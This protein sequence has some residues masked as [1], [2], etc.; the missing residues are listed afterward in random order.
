M[1]S[2]NLSLAF[3]KFQNYEPT[4]KTNKEKTPFSELETYTLS[5]NEL[6][7]LSYSN[8]E[9]FTMYPHENSFDIKEYNLGLCEK[10]NFAIPKFHLIED[11]IYNMSEYK[12]STL[13]E[14]QQ[15][16]TIIEN[17]IETSF[18]INYETHINLLIEKCKSNFKNELYRSDNSHGYFDYVVNELFNYLELLNKNLFRENTY[19]IP[20]SRT[21]KTNFI[22]L[23][24]W[25][26]Q[27][28]SV[29]INIENDKRLKTAIFPRIHQPTFELK[30][31]S[32]N[33]ND[34]ATLVSILE[35]NK[36]VHKDTT[37]KDFQKLF[38]NKS[39]FDGYINWTGGIVSLHS[40]LKTLKDNRII[41]SKNIWEIG[42]R[43][44]LINEKE[45]TRDQLKNTSFTKNINKKTTLKEISTTLK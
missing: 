12:N 40:F 34:F 18:I 26:Y 42:S 13:K 1:F 20:I 33:I 3:F 28:F 2:D 16:L 45:I 29:Y 17:G 21:I 25:I 5:I 24:R 19:F 22:N 14:F 9:N 11:L 6:K 36:L 32:K 37:G 15:N 35:E 44:F 31:K 41:K 43:Y 23:L 4:I 10:E 27:N 8:L 30:N 38:S 7:K 39:Y